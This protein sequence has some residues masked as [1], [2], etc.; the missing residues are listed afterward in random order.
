MTDLPPY[1]EAVTADRQIVVVD[2]EST[3]LDRAMHVP[4]EVAFWVLDTGVRGVFIPVHTDVDIQNAQLEAL[5]INRYHERGLWQRGRWDWNAA[6]LRE[7]HTALTGNTMVGSNPGFDAG[8]LGPLFRRYRLDPAPWH[9][10]SP[11]DVGTYAAGVLGL[12]IGS[13]FKLTK[14]CEALNIPPGDHSAGNDVTAT[15][16][17]LL[18][19][20]RR[21]AQRTAA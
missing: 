3:G 5:R 12:P 17:C 19:L 14:L 11:L 2:V 21:A 8:M 13:R 16:R 1:A 18:E 9:Y 7:L 15:G 6:G 4:V 10:A 20:Q